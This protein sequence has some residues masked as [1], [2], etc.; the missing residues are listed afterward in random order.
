MPIDNKPSSNEEIIYQRQQ[1]VQGGIGRVY[2]D[3]RDR[4]IIE[5]IAGDNILDIGCGEGITLEK[6]VK[7][8]PNKK[9]SGIDDLAE[10]VAIC[11]QYNLPV[12]KGNIYNLSYNDNSIDC[13]LFVEVI[14]HLDNYE[15]ALCEIYRVLKK[16]GRAIIVFPNDRIF[17]L[18][19]IITGKTKE[20]YY[21][22]GHVRQWTPRLIKREL[23]RLG[24]ESI[25][26][27][28]MPFCF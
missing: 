2:W 17:K 6:I 4:N 13:C 18:A 3:F 11:Q 19:R 9:V 10:N 23:K 25:T 1:Y 7:M 28:N 24:F 22:A 8:F 26:V 21:D 16:A 20:A 12:T 27:E 15:Q 14:E 5:N